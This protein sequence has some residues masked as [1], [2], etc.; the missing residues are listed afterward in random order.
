MDIADRWSLCIYYIDR[1]R[2][3]FSSVFFW[4]VMQNVKYGNNGVV[5]KKS[6]I[7]SIFFVI[8]S[9]IVLLSLL[10]FLV[11]KVFFD[12]KKD[13]PNANK[14]YSLWDSADYQ[15]VYDSSALILEQKPM[16]IIAN[17]F[18]GYS[19]FFLALSQTDISVAQSLLDES[20]NH[21]RFSIYYVDENTLPQ[22]YYMLGKA[23]FQKNTISSYHYYSDLAVKYLELAKSVGYVST[24][25]PEYLGLCYADLGMISESLASFTEAL[26]LRESDV[27]LLAIAQQYNKNSQNDIAK[28]YLFRINYE[29]EDDDLVLKSKLLLAD[30]YFSEG[31][32]TEAQKEYEEI[33]VK[34]NSVADAYFGLGNIFEKMGDT[35]KA[36]SEWRKTLKVQINH[37]GAIKKLGL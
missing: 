16:N 6:K 19:S 25:I 31:N 24:D 4:K 32:F 21:L 11:V 5:K 29:S 7:L 14:L 3:I 36:R 27:L 10:T 9:I 20:I 23:Y 8:L 26:L 13:I 35:A 33:L 2:L 37:S 28:Q 18:N 17:V 30:I 12:S 34:D 15:A 22:I 1:T